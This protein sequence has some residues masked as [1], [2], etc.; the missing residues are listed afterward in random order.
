MSY[1]FTFLLV[2][3]TAVIAFVV[4][5]TEIQENIKN[6]LLIDE[7]AVLK[8]FNSSEIDSF[9]VQFYDR[10]TKIEKNDNKWFISEPITEEGDQKYISDYI[11]RL[12]NLKKTK[13]YS[14]PNFENDIFGLSEDIH[15][16]RI[17]FQDK[18]LYIN[19]G[20]D[21]PTGKYFYFTINDTSAVYGDKS[22]MKYDLLKDVYD[23][24]KKDVFPN[25]D[26]E[27]VSK[28]ELYENE[29]KAEIYKNKTN[30]WMIKTEKYLDK[31]NEEIISAMLETAK[32]AE[33]KRFY[34][35]DIEAVFE[36]GKLDKSENKIAISYNNQNI[37][38]EFGRKIAMNYYCSR[39]IN[40]SR[41]KIFEVFQDVH[42][43]LIRDFSELRYPFLFDISDSL[44]EVTI[45]KNE[46]E[47][48][49][50]IID[51]LNFD[52]DF[53]NKKARILY[54]S[55]K[56]TILHRIEDLSEEEKS[57]KNSETPF[58]L[59][60]AEYTSGRNQR[61][62]I[63]TKDEDFVLNSYGR[64]NISAYLYYENFIETLKILK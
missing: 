26:A 60:E 19:I 31:A 42:H 62:E 49:L 35:D 2:L 22:L 5:V 51:S 40:G 47:K 27:Y 23:F 63:F 36:K 28:I 61:V 18:E 7:T 6:E 64:R 38:L 25:I 43:N 21:T 39:N 10:I 15:K 34:D 59:I 52:G 58:I 17:F 30:V 3:V 44:K 20:N 11:I 24:R 33:I 14:E 4:Y 41:E 13:K 50:I 46:E 57:V 53:D 9:W 12:K 56:K 37:E 32:K 1:K 54:S 8:D 45:K 16:I 55:L 48:S 29:G